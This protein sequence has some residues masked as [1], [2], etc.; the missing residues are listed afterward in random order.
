MDVNPYE[1]PRECGYA[2]TVSA[3][4]QSWLRDKLALLAIAH[5]WS[6]PIFGFPFCFWLWWTQ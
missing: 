5:L 2:A 3:P 4:E 6:I 1:S